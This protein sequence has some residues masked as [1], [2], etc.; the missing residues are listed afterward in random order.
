M[1]GVLSSS[2]R[3]NWFRLS[4]AALRANGHSIVVIYSY[5]YPWACT[6]RVRA[7]R[8]SCLIAFSDTSTGVTDLEA[9]PEVIKTTSLWYD[10][11]LVSEQAFT[12][13]YVYE[14]KELCDTVSVTYTNGRSSFYRPWQWRGI[15]ASMVTTSVRW[16]VVLSQLPQEQTEQWTI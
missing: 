15:G 4:W 11:E 12:L 7:V 8:V 10:L 16:I 1:S 14:S 9:V 2:P 6:N 3:L 5:Q 13:M